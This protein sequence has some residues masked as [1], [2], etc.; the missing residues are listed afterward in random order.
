MA[1]KKTSKSGKKTAK[2]SG[3]SAKETAKARPAAKGKK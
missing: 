2:K 3:T 1:E